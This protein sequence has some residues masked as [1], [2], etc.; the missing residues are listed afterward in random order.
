MDLCFFGG[1]NMAS[2]L[3]GG[4]MQGKVSLRRLHVIEPQAAVRESLTKKFS[5]AAQSRATQWTVDAQARPIS[6][7]GAVR[8]S[9]SSWP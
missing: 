6:P 7:I 8:I 9:G 1:G 2:A 4:L 3:I 5:A